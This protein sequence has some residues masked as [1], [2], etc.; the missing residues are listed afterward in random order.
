MDTLKKVMRCQEPSAALIEATK[1]RSFDSRRWAT[2]FFRNLA[3]DSWNSPDGHTDGRGGVLRGGPKFCCTAGRQVSTFN[4]LGK[5][6]PTV[7]KGS[8]RHIRWNT[9]S[10]Y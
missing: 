4:L 2:F 1:T 3:R 6:K 5:C 8:T 7:R 10:T 9:G